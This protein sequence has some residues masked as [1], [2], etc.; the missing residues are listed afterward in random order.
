MSI[1][2]LTAEAFQVWIADRGIGRSPKDP[3]SDRLVFAAGGVGGRWLYPGAAA[4]VPEFVSTL[5]SAVRRN[6]PY[7]VYP[8][9]GVCA[10]GRDIESEP[11]GRVW[12]TTAR[13]L[14]VSAGLRGA[15]GF[16]STDWNELCT[17]LFLQVTLGPQVG[18]D[19]SVIPETG[20]AVLSF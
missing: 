18:I 13:A 11:Q 16:N 6:E 15:V 10:P 9:R 2:T 5:L 3:H 12:M 1:R 14:G 4:R 20:S 7:W 17:M 8:E 19:M